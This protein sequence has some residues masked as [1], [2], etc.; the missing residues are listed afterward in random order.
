[1]KPISIQ[2]RFIK[3]KDDHSSGKSSI[4]QRT[5]VQGDQQETQ[6]SPTSSKPKQPLRALNPAMPHFESQQAPLTTDRLITFG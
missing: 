4:K 1:L 6:R 5:M 3:T 2:R